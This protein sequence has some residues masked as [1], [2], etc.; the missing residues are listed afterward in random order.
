MKRRYYRPR[1]RAAF[2]SPRFGWLGLLALVL[3]ILLHRLHSIATKSLGI[4]ALIPTIIAFIALMLAIR[5]LTALWQYGHKGGLAAFRGGLL[6]LITLSPMLLAV[7]AWIYFPP[8]SEVSTD[9]ETPP[10][11]LPGLRPEDA[12]PVDDDFSTRAEEQLGHWP[13]L[14]SRRYDGSPDN[15][16]KAVLAVINNEGWTITGQKGEAGED[17]ELFVQATAKTLVLGFMSDIVIRLADEGDT[18]FVDIRAASRYLPHDFGMDARFAI[19]FM[20]ALDTEVL[21]SP[22]E[23][24]EE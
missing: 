14:S 11:F 22:G 1:S 5:G 19:A 4:Y 17:T 23:Q 8:L 6:A 3:V 15:I 24:T 9:F 13:Q 7:G 12:L 18:T 2:W 10:D 20:E 16:L 21:L